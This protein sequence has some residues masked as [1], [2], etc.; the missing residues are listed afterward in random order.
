MSEGSV[1]YFPSF[2]L[3]YGN[4]IDNVIN[5]KSKKCFSQQW[6]M[7]VTIN[8]DKELTN[9]Y[10]HRVTYGLVDVY[11]RNSVIVLDVPFLLSRTCYDIFPV[12]VTINF[13][14]WTGLEECTFEHLLN[15][16]PEG[17]IRSHSI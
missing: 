5:P 6:T 14:P 11:K 7:F 17:F 12:K 15:F 1:E 13:Q 9:K 3:T 10:I 8:N 16:K 2:Q 4:N